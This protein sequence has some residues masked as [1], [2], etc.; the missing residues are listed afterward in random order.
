MTLQ[1]KSLATI[2]LPKILELL[3]AEAATPPAKEL[4]RQLRPEVIL[5][6]CEKQ[7]EETEDASRMIGLQGSPAFSGVKDISNALERAEKGGFL[8]PV[9]LL[10]VG[11]LLRAA[12][13]TK[14]YREERRDQQQSSLDGYFTLLTGNKFLE[15][16]IENA[17]VSEEEISDHASSELYQIRRQIRTASAKVRDVLAKITSSNSKAL[18]DNIVTQRNGRFVVP[19]KAEYR[20]TFPGMVHDTS[21]SGATLFVE[22]AAVVELNNNIRILTGKEKAE[23]ERILAEL[24][25]EAAGYRE[26]INLDYDMLVQLDVIFPKA[27]LSYRMH[28]WA[29]IMNDQGRVELR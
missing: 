7:Q 19:V 13:L 20:S 24:S 11:A 18:Q 2:E 6:Q 23:I 28:A 29:P 3:A 12:R 1:E 22:P 14:A 21:S 27:K 16:K 9:E 15:D 5:S 26:S 17:I 10:A 4:C 25:A 8:N